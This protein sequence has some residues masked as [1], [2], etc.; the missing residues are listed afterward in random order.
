M[1]KYMIIGAVLISSM[2]F[3]QKGTPKLEVVDN[4]VKATY[5]YDNGKIQQEGFFKD[6]KLEGQWVAYDAQGKKLSVGEYSN[7]QK[8]G[9]WFF[10]NDA[11]SS[12]VDYSN[13]QVAYVT[14]H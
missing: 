11:K 12:Q 7:G 4:M 8:V 1:K 5:Y 6:G 9:K 14:T 13:N 10:Y 3:A 2:I